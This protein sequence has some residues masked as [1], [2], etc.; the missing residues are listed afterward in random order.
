MIVKK[1]D[2]P[3]LS[4]GSAVSLVARLRYAIKGFADRERKHKNGYVIGSGQLKDRL[5]QSLEQNA[6]RLESEIEATTNAYAAR[7]QDV[8]ATFKQRV[9]RIERAHETAKGILSNRVRSTTGQGKYDRQ[10]QELQATRERDAAIVHAKEAFAGVKKVVAS[11]QRD[12]KDM[13]KLARNSFRGYPKFGRELKRQMRSTDPLPD[14]P[15]DD[16]Q[17]LG[18]FGHPVFFGSFQLR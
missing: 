9:D 3:L 4:A 17:V 8:E 7:R 1:K 5:E 10:K 2:N 12:L 14:A 11:E 13:E 15:D 6:A 16:Q 18:N